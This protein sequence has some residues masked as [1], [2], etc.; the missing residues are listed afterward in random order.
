MCDIKIIH[1]FLTVNK[2]DD[3][4]S[5]AHIIPQ[6]HLKMEEEGIPLFLFVTV[7]ENLPSSIIII[8][9]VTVA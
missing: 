6:I 8:S 7:S 9:R 1:K 2:I 3:Q 5:R 4:V